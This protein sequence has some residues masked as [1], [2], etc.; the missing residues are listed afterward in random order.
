METLWIATYKMKNGF[1][2]NKNEYT[3]KLDGIS[4]IDTNRIAYVGN[5]NNCLFGNRE[6]SYSNR[7]DFAITQDVRKTIFGNFVNGY[8]SVNQSVIRLL[9]KNNY[10]YYPS[11]LMDF[12]VSLKIDSITINKIE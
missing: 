4:F 12:Y 2:F 11:E 9:R 8:D 3:S 5:D 1:L 7:F 10:K 6:P